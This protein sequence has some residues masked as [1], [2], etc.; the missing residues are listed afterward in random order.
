MKKLKGCL[1]VFL[2]F[3]LGV[4]VG[5][6]LASGSIYTKVWELI[7]RGPDRVAEFTLERVNDE[8]KLDS[9][10]R[11]EFQR[12]ADRTRLRLR[13]I[14]YR[15]QPETDA[16]IDESSAE[17]LAILNPKQQKKFDELMKRFRGKWRAENPDESEGVNWSESLKEE[18]KAPVTPAPPLPVEATPPGPQPQPEAPA[19][20]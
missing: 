5:A 13:A 10:Q 2:I 8:L 16:A 12:I 18:A 7:E 17:L 11:R 20:R 14:R 3:F 9:V 1:G 15:Q 19:D 6:I 4:V